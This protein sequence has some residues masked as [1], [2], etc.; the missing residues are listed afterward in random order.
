[1]QIEFCHLLPFLK[2]FAQTAEKQVYIHGFDESKDELPFFNI[3]RNIE[4]CILNIPTRARHVEEDLFEIKV[5]S[6]EKCDQDIFENFI[7]NQRHR[8]FVFA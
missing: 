7:S 6:F 1:M 5:E 4:E 8:S 3:F 2:V